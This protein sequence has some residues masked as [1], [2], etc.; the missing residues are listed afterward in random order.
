MKPSRRTDWTADGRAVFWTPGYDC[1]IKCEH[2]PKGDHGQHGDELLLAVRQGEIAVGLTVFTFVRDRA[3]TYH[4]SDGRITTG[5]NL[6]V[7]VPWPFNEDQIRERAEGEPHCELI[8]P[9]CFSTCL[10]CCRAEQIWTLAEEEAIR[11]ALFGDAVERSVLLLDTGIW[12]RLKS[13]AVEMEKWALD[14]RAGLRCLCPTC[15]GEG[16]IRRS[17]G[18][19]S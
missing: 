10:S 1:R 5:A 3:V 18:V 8:K 13:E 14:E 15:N 16:L 7:H 17:T 2:E 4:Q 9:P 6:S 19:S 11:A 12:N